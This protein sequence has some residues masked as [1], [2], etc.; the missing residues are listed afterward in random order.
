MLNYVQGLLWSSVC[1]QEFPWNPWIS[2]ESMDFHGSPR[3]SMDF[4]GFPWISMDHLYISDKTWILVRWIFDGFPSVTFPI[5]FRYFFLGCHSK[6]QFW[7][8]RR[9]EPPWRGSRGRSP[10]PSVTIKPWSPIIIPENFR[11]SI[12]YCLRTLL[13]DS[14]WFSIDG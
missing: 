2:I 1:F 7:G 13:H 10:P 11:H 12:F 4:H 9:A 14:T 3:T 8:S 5:D 6:P